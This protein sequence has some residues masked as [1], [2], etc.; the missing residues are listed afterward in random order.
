MLRLGLACALTLTGACTLD[1]DIVGPQGGGAAG[2]SNTGASGG[3]MSGGAAEGG[4]PATDCSGGL[5]EC[6]PLPDGFDGAVV[7]GVG[8][9]AAEKVFDG[10]ESY[11]FAP[12][13]CGCSCV[14]SE[15]TCT[16]PGSAQAFSSSTCSTNG[17]VIDLF[18]TDTCIELP[19]LPN[20]VSIKLVEAGTPP[21]CESDLKPPSLPPVEWS[22]PIVGCSFES[23]GCGSDICLPGPE[24]RY[25]FYRALGEAPIGCPAGLIDTPVVQEGDL[26]DGRSCECLCGPKDF[27]GCANP[28]W[29][30]YK[31][32]SCLNVFG[33]VQAVCADAGDEIGSTAVT[34]D[35]DVICAQNEVPTG[36]V[37]ATPK[38]QACCSPP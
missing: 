11:A 25:C 14:T 38:I 6:V 24:E 23:I 30:L 15:D 20:A 19:S 1:F 29:S 2:A 16:V 9:G 12:A 32:T 21:L 10:F 35:S 26:G 37:A 5:G 8:C 4:A 33:T 17:S 28:Q 18:V 31:D 13:L 7:L 27:D 36:T 22:T 3:S 34:I